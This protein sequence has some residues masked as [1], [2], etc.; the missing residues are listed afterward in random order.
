M[1]A[2]PGRKWSE[3]RGEYAEPREL[4][5]ALRDIATGRGIT[6][7]DLEA[8]MPYGH[9]AISEN[10]NG[11]QRPAWRFAAALLDAC[12]D[13]DQQ[14]RDVLHRRVRPLWEAAAPD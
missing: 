8:R 13:G 5:S 9:S 6:L 12:A 11:A 1:A 2:R 3:L 7:R 4:A 10:L 14:A